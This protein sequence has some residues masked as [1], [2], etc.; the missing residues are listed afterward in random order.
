[1]MTREKGKM[2][3]K[4]YF[5]ENYDPALKYGDGTVVSFS[6]RVSYQLARRNISYRIPEDFY[7]EKELRQGEDEYFFEQLRW[8]D[9]LDEFLRSRI[10]YFEANSIRLAR[11]YYNRIKYLVDPALIQAYI[12]GRIIE[13]LPAGSEIVY[14]KF[15]DKELPRTMEGFKFDEEAACFS[16]LLPLLC[17][18]RPSIR[19]SFHF[20]EAFGNTPGPAGAVKPSPVKIAAKW[21]ADLAPLRSA[22]LFFKYGGWRYWGRGA[23]EKTKVLFLHAGSLHLDPV[24]RDF[25]AAGADVSLLLGG[26]I[27]DLKRPWIVEV[28]AGKNDLAGGTLERLKKDIDACFR[29]FSGAP[30]NI[31]SW[32]NRRSGL[33]LTAFLKPFFESFLRDTSEAVVSRSLAFEDFYRRRKIRCVVTHTSSDLNSKSAVVA[34]RRSGTVRSVCI[35]HGC[36]VFQDKIWHITEMDPFDFYLAT[37]GISA[38]KYRRGAS[39]AYVKKCAVFESPHYLEAVGRISQRPGKKAGGYGRTVLYLPTTLSMHARYFNNMVYPILWYFEYLKK[40]LDYFEGRKGEPRFI[41][42]HRVLRRKYYEESII[43]HIADRGFKHISVSTLPVAEALAGVDAVILDRPT[44][45]LFEAVSSGLPV[46]CLYPRMVEY[47]VMDEAKLQFGR[48]LQVF[49]DAQDACLKIDEFLDG[50]RSRYVQQLRLRDD[51]FPE[52]FVNGVA[53]TLFGKAL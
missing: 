29:D 43:P 53:G 10:A 40:L 5:V 44:T 37:D 18:R 45:A 48:S 26:R 42:K 32:V 15:Q 41:Y 12:L 39:V 8:I 3:E 19:Y 27:F 23:V 13:R 20:F 21:F 33:D 11:I 31:L 34:A 51:G 9:G 36:D 1:M 46:L 28:L 14:V 6:P 7:S 49:E 50:D 30:E 17:A 16:V 4:Y 52:K 35:Q 24:I 38:V 2:A 47:E 22:Y 25:L